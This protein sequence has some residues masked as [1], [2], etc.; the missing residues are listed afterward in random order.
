[1]LSDFNE[2]FSSSENARN[3]SREKF[4][5]AIVLWAGRDVRKSSSSAAAGDT[6]VLSRQPKLQ[7]LQLRA[8]AQAGIQ[9]QHINFHSQLRIH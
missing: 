9:L 5:Q 8:D 3:G 6:S 4:S 7:P 2:R 1:V